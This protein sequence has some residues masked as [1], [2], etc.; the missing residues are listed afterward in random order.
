[1]KAPRNGCFACRQTHPKIA[2]QAGEVPLR[3]LTVRHPCGGR[4]RGF[5]LSD[6]QGVEGIKAGIGTSVIREAVTDAYGASTL[7]VLHG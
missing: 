3:D 4:E 1:M 2:W 7:R 6:P 5:L